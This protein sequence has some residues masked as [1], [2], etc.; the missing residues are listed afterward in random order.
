MQ[1]RSPFLPKILDLLGRILDRKGLLD[2]TVVSWISRLHQTCH[3]WQSKPFFVV[4]YTCTYYPVSRLFFSLL[5]MKKWKL[6][7]S[8]IRT[9]TKDQSRARIKKKGETCQVTRF[10][11]FAWVWK[12][13]LLR[14]F[15]WRRVKSDYGD[16]LPSS[17]PFLGP[18]RASRSKNGISRR[19]SWLS[20][21]SI[22]FGGWNWWHRST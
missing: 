8:K 22:L 13:S 9:R 5:V 2:C 10:F 15:S 7:K 3:L 6:K 17:F 18:T 20:N 12:V 14:K 19:C 1:S 16:F 21:R 11:F 4:V